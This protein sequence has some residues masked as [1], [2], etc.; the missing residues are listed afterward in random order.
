MTPDHTP[1][2]VPARTP[3]NPVGGGDRAHFNNI[4]REQQILGPQIA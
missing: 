4:E 1:R 2:G 3:A